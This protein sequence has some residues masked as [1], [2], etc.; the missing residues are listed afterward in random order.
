MTFSLTL[1][2]QRELAY[3]EYG[4]GGGI[5]VLSFHG[6]LSSRLDAAPAHEAA[7]KLGIRLISPD[8]PGMGRS[9]F[10]PDRRLVDW[11]TDVA[12]LADALGLDHFAVMGWSAGGAY[13]AVCAAL[14]PGRVTSAA[15]LSS[16]VPLDEYGTTRGLTPDD[17]M[18][19]VLVRWAP[20]VAAAL[21]RATIGDASDLR[22]FHEMRRSF[23]SPDRAVLDSRGSPAEAVAFVR[24]SMRRGTKGCL[25]DYR[26]FGAPWGFDLGTIG[27]P[28][29]LWEGTEDH[30]GPPDYRE[31]LLRRIPRSTFFPASGEGH[32]SLLTH[33]AEGILQQL[34]ASL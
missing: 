27:V 13:A 30:T 6:G 9:T 10:Q 20:F 32:I 12:A 15:L 11:P 3:E 34:V 22:L 24:E 25:Q 17:R 14:M 31:F 23:P 16:G 7:L 1:P 8:R 21:M 18:L 4:D 28:V 5:P 2:D 26:I 19:L 29:Q 33:Q